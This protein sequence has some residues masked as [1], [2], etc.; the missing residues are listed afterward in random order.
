L[1]FSFK[2]KHL[3]AVARIIGELRDKSEA[4]RQLGDI[5]Q[6]ASY[7]TSMRGSEGFI[8]MRVT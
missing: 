4:K 7:C 1:H 2:L 8:I 3:V 6:F 5:D